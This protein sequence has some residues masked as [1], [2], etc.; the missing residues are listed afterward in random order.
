MG[1]MF[2]CSIPV[3]TWCNL[4]TSNKTRARHTQRVKKSSPSLAKGGEKTGAKM[5]MEEDDEDI[6]IKGA[7]KVLRRHRDSKEITLE[8]LAERVGVN[9]S[10]LHRYE[11]DET[12]LSGQMIKR[13]AKGL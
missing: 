3:N 8:L 1:L 6:F 5:A 4:T 7:G 10:T 2:G 12:P 13:I 9:K 11:T